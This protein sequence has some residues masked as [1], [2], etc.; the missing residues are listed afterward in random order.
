MANVSGSDPTVTNC[1]F[2]GNLA[3]SGSAGFNFSSS[4]SYVSCTFQGNFASPRLQGSTVFNNDS[5]PT[6]ANCLIWANRGADPG[7]F[8]SVGSTA[9]GTASYHSCL[10]EYHDAGSL[11]GTGNLDGI[12]DTDGDGIRITRAT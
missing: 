8:Q 1:V 2:S 11:G 5:S 4:P 12:T 10:I 9:G 6:M 7:P 3:A